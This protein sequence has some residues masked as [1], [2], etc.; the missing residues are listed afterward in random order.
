MNNEYRLQLLSHG[1]IFPTREEAVEYI[2]DNFKGE[3]LWSEPAVFFYGTE[4]DPKMILAVGASKSATRPRICTIDD[5]E[6]RELIAAVQEATDDNTEKIENAAKR[7]LEIVNA[8]GLTYDENKINNQISYDPDSRDALIGQAQ[9][10]AEA[11]AIIST[12]IQ[13]KFKENELTVVDGKSIDFDFTKTENGSTLTAEVKISEDGSDDELN[14]NDNIVGLKPDGVFAS[15]N[16]EYDSERNRLIFTTSGI[17]NGRFV[18]DA[19][20][21]IIDF[22]AHTIYTADNEDHNVQLVINQDTHKISADVKIAEDEWNL[23]QNHSGRLLVDGK[24]KNIK[25]KGTTVADQLNAYG[26]AIN[27]IKDK[28][29]F[30]ELEDL[31]EGDESDTIL[32]KAIKKQN[33][34]YTI[35]AD[36]RL[37]SDDSIQVANG[38]L[39]ANVDII[40]DSTNNKLIL[41]VGNNEKVISLPG[42]SI[43]DDIYYD[44][45]N[46]VI[47]I[48]WKDGTQQTII[49]VGDMLKTWIIEN[50]QLSPV[51]LTKTESSV[52]GQPEVLSADLKIAQTDNLIGKDAYGQIYVRKSEIDNKIDAEKTA[53]EA[54]DN[55]LNNLIS[56]TSQTLSERI[57]EEANTRHQEDDDIRDSINNVRT[58]AANALSNAVEEINDKIDDT[59]GEIYS[60]IDSD[61]NRIAQVESGLTLTNTNLES[62]ISRATTAETANTNAINAEVTRATGVENAIAN[63]VTS[64]ESGLATE[65]E[66][67]NTADA[68]HDEQISN[69]RSAVTSAEQSHREDIERLSSEIEENADAIAIINGSESVSGS[70][71]EA[72]KTAK[73][74][75]TQMVAN[76]KSRAETAEQRLETL[77]SNEVSRATQG[78]ADTLATSKAY[79][80]HAV[81]DSKHLSDD[82]TDAAKL[83]AINTSKEYT[84][85]KFESAETSS[86]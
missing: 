65:R 6:L 23:L 24:A 76:E 11:V 49:P 17:K 1:Q 84:D 50:N 12:F 18:T 19:N 45:A 46:K 14:F 60:R 61:E 31:I 33:G 30:L 34:G 57:T 69:L 42:V 7:I 55:E 81:A 29:E 62:E 5:A 72:V 52:S 44:S 68:V 56:T 71:R 36:V 4:R 70:I 32:T 47:V 37:S 64:L 67:R 85:S 58:E 73:D 40:V 35:S 78:E 25:Y 48:T 66:T 27:E 86:N 10:V 79:T 75:A 26:T 77:I 38:G 3:A 9:S 15:C 28:I 63:R 39:K 80:D 16:I 43:L 22:G 53:R 8:V 83:E 59:K 2:E 13:S 41:K 54:A 51:V 20:R 21:K 74:E 82:Y